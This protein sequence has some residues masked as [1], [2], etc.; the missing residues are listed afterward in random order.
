MLLCINQRCTYFRI[1]NSIIKRIRKIENT[2]SLVQV[3]DFS[4]VFSI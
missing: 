2:Y 1:D 3:D 4:L